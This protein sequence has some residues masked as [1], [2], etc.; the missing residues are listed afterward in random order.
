MRI[1][2]SISQ[3]ILGETKI[4][5]IPFITILKVM[6]QLKNSYETLNAVGQMRWCIVEAASCVPVDLV[7]LT[8]VYAAAGR[9]W[10]ILLIEQ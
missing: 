9:W 7:D 4:D 1:E 3:V 8:L 6:T 10:Y 2:D 5:D